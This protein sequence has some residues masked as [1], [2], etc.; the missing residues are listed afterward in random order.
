MRILPI[1]LTFLLALFW[2]KP[3]FAVFLTISDAPQ[4]I[5]DQSFSLNVSISGA[6]AGTN[7]LRVDL[8]KEG[9][10]NYFGETYNG[11]DWYGGSDGKQYY[12]ITI[13]SGQTW[14]DSVQ[15]RIGTP[16]TGKYPGPGNYKLRIRRYTSSGGTGTT[17][18]TPQDIQITFAL[19]SPSPTPTEFPS[20][21][22]TPSPSPNPTSIP[23][24]TALS[25]SK[26][27]TTSTASK[28]PAPTTN[29]TTQPPTQ[30]TVTRPISAKTKPKVNYQIA[31]VT[32]VTIS[33]NPSAKVEIKSQKQINYY[34]WTGVILI[35]AG[36]SSIVYIYLRKNADT[37]IK[38]RSRD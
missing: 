10:S 14:N 1:F 28:T 22:P 15:G 23:T 11:N 27:K 30:E 13:V 12:P 21:T 7:Y 5:T 18:Q 35:F 26:A 17:D 36:I 31:S 3:A 34:V 37:R 20:P 9:T 24:P 6:G 33:P 32:A 4:I 25:S 19:P 29:P 16:T 38:L 2:V 8:Y